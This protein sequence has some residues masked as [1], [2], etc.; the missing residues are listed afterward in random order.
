MLMKNGNTV[1]PAPCTALENDAY[2]MKVFMRMRPSCQKRYSEKV[3]ASISDEA[4][5]R[6][7]DSIITE[8]HKYGERHNY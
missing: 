7:I 5:N 8:I 2:A 6:R 4:A 3:T 1:P